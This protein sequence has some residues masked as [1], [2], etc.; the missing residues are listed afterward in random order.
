MVLD[1]GHVLLERAHRGQDLRPQDR[2]AL[3]RLA[4]LGAEV[5]GF[6]EDLVQHA[7]LADVVQEGDLADDLDIILRQAEGAP[8]EQREAG[9]A[10]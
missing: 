10:L 8:D 9:H 1:A 4:L 7:D 5:R 2:V 3:D 6:V